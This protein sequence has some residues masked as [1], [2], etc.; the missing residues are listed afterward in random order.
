M[1][2]VLPLSR[3]TAVNAPADVPR[4]VALAGWDA[5]AIDADAALGEDPA[6]AERVVVS[7]ALG[8]FQ[9]AP[10]RDL[11]LDEGIV[12]AGALLGW[13]DGQEVRSPFSGRFMGMLAFPGG[14]VV[15]GEPVA[16][17]RP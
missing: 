2:R 17:L 12:R 1:R 16:W 15:K 13:V 6:I 3:T 10:S 8:V 14:P 4:A 5:L 9:P 11:P 7:P